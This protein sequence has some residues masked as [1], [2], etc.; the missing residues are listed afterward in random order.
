MSAVR[1]F[2]FCVSTLLHSSTAERNATTTAAGALCSTVY[3]LN[4]VPYPDSGDMAGWDRGFELIPAGH[5]A[6]AHINN[7][8]DL[9]GGLKVEIVDIGSEACGR[10]LVTDGQLGVYEKIM[11]TPCVAGVIG[12]FCSAVTELVVPVA[13]HSMYGYIQLSS[14]TSPLLND[15]VKF[16]YVFH[17]ISSSEVFNKAMIALMDEFNWTRVSVIHDSMGIYFDS[18]GK[19]F[20]RLMN[21]EPNKTLL[22]SSPIVP[23]DRDV[24]I[25][26]KNINSAQSTIG[27]FSVTVEESATIMCEAFRRNQLWRDGYVYVFHERTVED[28]INGSDVPCKPE[29]MLDAIEGVYS[30]QYRLN[31]VHPSNLVSGISYEVYHQ[32]YL[33]E[34]RKFENETGM[35]LEDNEYANTLYDQVWAFALALN[36]SLDRFGLINGSFEASYETTPNL[37]ETLFEELQKVEFNG[38]TGRMMFGK[39]QEAET[40]VDIFQIRNG[41]AELI[42]VVDSHTSSISFTEN[43]SVRQDLPDD[44]PDTVRYLLPVWLGALVLAAQGA[45]LTLIITNT[46]LLVYLRNSPEIKSSS[47]Y[48]SL[49]ILVGCYFLCVSSV[50]YAVYS[51]VYITDAVVF[52]VLCYMELWLSSNGL[53]LVIVPL[54]FRLLRIFH[55][56]AT[57]RSTGKHWSDKYLICYIFLVCSVMVIILIVWNAVAPFHL[58]TDVM[59]IRPRNHP[60]YN[61]EYPYCSSKLPVLWSLLTSGWIGLILVVVL[62]LA[63]KTRHIKRKNYKDTKKVNMFVFSVSVILM[64]FLPLSYIMVAVNVLLGAFVFKWLAFSLV[65]FLCQIF[66]FMPKNFP[67][68]LPSRKKKKKHYAGALARTAFI[69]SLSSTQY[70]DVTKL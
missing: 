20:A 52:T 62:L 63:I 5:L 48:I 40:F 7:R 54:L 45:L 34:L 55:V 24:S 23:T 46:V 59:Y 18:T 28:M 66:I 51:S 9:L 13:N 3:L 8:T 37:R 12:L 65:A 35:A 39:E 6:T 32:Q 53:S 42:G 60:P 29:Q 11:N 61:L 33:G 56:F 17:M 10:S 41:H 68:L 14:S 50:L 31:T 36:N 38:V 64:T 67:V 22:S 25:I 57:F 43:F 49:I 47:F 58:V 15:S 16:P 4:V 26:F 21:S 44:R 2:L 27:Y 30:L 70:T 1:L 69:A 19:N